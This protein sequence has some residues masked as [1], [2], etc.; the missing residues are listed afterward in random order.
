[1][2]EVRRVLARFRRP[3]AAPSRRTRSR[4]VK[5]TAPP[6]AYGDAADKVKAAE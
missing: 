4:A 6:P 3:A 5:R 2:H 1:M